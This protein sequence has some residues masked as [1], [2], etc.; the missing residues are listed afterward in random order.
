[1]PADERKV[2][3]HGEG[4]SSRPCC[5][6]DSRTNSQAARLSKSLF[7]EFPDAVLFEGIALL[8]MGKTHEACAALETG[9]EQQDIRHGGGHERKMAMMLALARAKVE[10]EHAAALVRTASRQS[11]ISRLASISSNAGDSDPA[12]ETLPTIPSAVW[13]SAPPAGG[14]LQ[15]RHVAPSAFPSI[16]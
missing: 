1:M 4:G 10:D 16:I 9:L 5:P 11:V 12:R 8:G 2:P 15:P 3:L 6:P 14:S 13:P 7:A